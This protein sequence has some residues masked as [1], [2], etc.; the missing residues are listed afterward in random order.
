VTVHD[1]DALSMLTKQ[2]A[3]NVTVGSFSENHCANF[4]EPTGASA[5]ISSSE[6][7]A[8]LTSSLFNTPKN[9]DRYISIPFAWHE[10]LS[11]SH[12][13][14]SRPDPDTESIT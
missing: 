7:T 8:R 14:R 1:S 2:R 11:A 12:A 13:S 9:T 10:K 6:L 3:R 5:E 4:R